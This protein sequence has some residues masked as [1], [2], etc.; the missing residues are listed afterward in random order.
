MKALKLAATVTLVVLGA[1]FYSAKADAK[2]IHNPNQLIAQASPLQVKP[3]LRDSQIKPANTNGNNSNVETQ[4][5]QAYELLKKDDYKG[6]IALFNKVLQTEQNNE[7]ATYAYF[8]RGIAYLS[9]DKYE[10]AKSDFDQ[11]ITLDA[12]FAHAYFFRAGTQYQLGNKN[13]AISDLNQAV[14]LFK[15]QGE[16]EL[17]KKAEDMIE[18]IQTS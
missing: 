12:K 9:I 16:T 18:K 5:S 14:S 11:V 3:Q 15:A 1:S 2:D 8:G 6:A 4:L 10:A 7:S 13:E 17:A